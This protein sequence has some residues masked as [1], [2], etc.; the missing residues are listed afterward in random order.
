MQQETKRQKRLRQG[1][2]QA[3]PDPD[4]QQTLYTLDFL[5]VVSHDLPQVSQQRTE[6][7]RTLLLQNVFERDDDRHNVL[8]QVLLADFGDQ[9]GLGFRNG[10]D[11]LV[12]VIP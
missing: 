10:G 1:V 3:G 11:F 4:N 7:R 8:H 5:L 9:V 2:A 6:E 12:G